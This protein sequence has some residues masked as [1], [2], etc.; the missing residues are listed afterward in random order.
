MQHAEERRQEGRRDLVIKGRTNA[1]APRGSRA[2]L[3]GV[4]FCIE[5]NYR[6]E[7]NRAVAQHTAWSVKACGCKP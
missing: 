5:A 7:I 3:R 6:G 2:C 4:G 1:H